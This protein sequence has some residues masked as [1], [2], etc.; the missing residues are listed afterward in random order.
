MSFGK[1]INQDTILIGNNRFAGY[2]TNGGSNFTMFDFE[3]LNIQGFTVNDLAFD[4][5]GNM[6]VVSPL[7]IFKANIT[8]GTITEI[9][10]TNLN[11]S[12]HTAVSIVGEKLYIIGT[13]VIGNQA[14]GIFVKTDTLNQFFEETI[15]PFIGNGTG[16]QFVNENV[17]WITALNNTWIYKTTN[18]GVTW[19]QQ[20]TGLTNPPDDF[21]FHNENF[22][23]V[24]A[25]NSEARY[26]TDGGNTWLVASNLGLPQGLAGKLFFFNQNLGWYGTG[27]N[28]TIRRTT[29]GGISWQNF[30]TGENSRVNRVH[31]F[32]ENQGVAATANNKL[33]FS[34]NGG[35]SWNFLYQM[36]VSSGSSSVGYIRRWDENTYEYIQRFEFPFKEFIS[37]D[38]GISWNRK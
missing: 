25:A 28:G 10:A 30:T 37:T 34:N 7:H 15:L 17:G 38:G 26:T 8:S 14:T 18:G 27:N 4:T 11:N 32:N 35:V 13:T 6:V 3:P 19:T 1:I 22:G 12:F 36:P 16:I 33:F 2:S 23:V 31:F 21:Y 29:N 5:D 20:I 9:L 24:V